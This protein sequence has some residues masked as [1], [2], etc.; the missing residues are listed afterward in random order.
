MRSHDKTQTHLE[1]RSQVFAFKITQHV[2][3]R[4]SHITKEEQSHPEGLVLDDKLDPG[5]R[6]GAAGYIVGV[7]T[8]QLTRELLAENMSRLARFVDE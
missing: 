1:K 7:Y 3:F 4:K 8:V 6:G 2:S 5:Y